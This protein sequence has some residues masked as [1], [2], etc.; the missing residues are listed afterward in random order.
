MLYLSSVPWSIRPLTTHDVF[1]FK[2]RFLAASHIK[3]H[4]MSG[5]PSQESVVHDIY[6]RLYIRTSFS[7]VCTCCISKIIRPE[8]LLR[9]LY[10]LYIKDHTSVHPSQEPVHDVYQR[11]YV[12]ISFSGVCIA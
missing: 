9:S 4:N 5:N 12:R 7:G 11:L 10:M 8:I 3:Y 6:Q 2:V 1:I